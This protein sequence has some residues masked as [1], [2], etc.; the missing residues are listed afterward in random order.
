MDKMYMGRLLHA[1]AGSKCYSAHIWMENKSRL[2]LC[3]SVEGVWRY[4]LGKVDAHTHGAMHRDYFIV[5]L[6]VFWGGGINA[7]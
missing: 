6:P 3:D 1:E 4:G 7:S 5:P 2:I